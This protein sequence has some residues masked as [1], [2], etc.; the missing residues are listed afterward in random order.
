MIDSRLAS[1][2]SDF[3]LQAEIYCLAIAPV[4]CYGML[5]LAQ[6]V[7]SQVICHKS[8]LRNQ[9]VNQWIETLE[10]KMVFKFIVID[11]AK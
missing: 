10:G 7:A 6:F 9:I 3:P 1:S 5:P 8:L 11:Q 2:E 4:H